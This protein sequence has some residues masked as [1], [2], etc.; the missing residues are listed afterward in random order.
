MRVIDSFLN[1]LSQY[2]DKV[3]S[4]FIWIIV[5]TIVY[6]FLIRNRT[7]MVDGA[8]GGNKF[9]ELPEQYGYISLYVVF[10]I[11]TYSSFF[12]YELPVMVWYFI[13]GLV[14]YIVGGRWLF[15]WALAFRAGKTEVTETTIN[16][17]TGNASQKIEKTEIKEDTK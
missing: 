15:D 14:M 6:W 13:M 10:S 8:S 1:Y 3:E 4:M 11:V 16:T 17:P 5:N 9:F 12:R 2:P 7:N